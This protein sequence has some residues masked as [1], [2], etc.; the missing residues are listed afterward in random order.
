MFGY[1]FSFQST[2]AFVTLF[3]SLLMAVGTSVVG[4][5]EIG[6]LSTSDWV[7]VALTFLGGSV[8]VGILD[9]V[10]GYFGGV[11][12]CV[13]GAAVAGLTA[14]QVAFE[15]DQVVTQGEWLGVVIAVFLALSAVY[16][17]PDGP[18]EDNPAIRDNS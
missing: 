14:Y 18:G 16:Q 3:V 10:K 9:N 1:N 2:K 17:I 6:D 5:S 12:K 15:N 13:V 8:V 7:K 4:D 11:I